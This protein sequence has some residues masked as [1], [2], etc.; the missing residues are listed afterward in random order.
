MKQVRFV[1]VIAVTAALFV[2]FAVGYR[3]GRQRGQDDQHRQDVKFN[4]AR[5]LKFHSQ[6]AR[7]DTN[8]LRND[9]ELWILGHTTTFE[10]LYG[11]QPVPEGFEGHLAE[12]QEI[13]ATVRKNS[14]HFDSAQQFIDRLNEEILQTNKDAP[15]L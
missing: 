7:G 11:S 1:P 4:L 3:I 10:E 5:T 8:Q 9:L 2:A 12:G 6:L 13:S 14:V 15:K